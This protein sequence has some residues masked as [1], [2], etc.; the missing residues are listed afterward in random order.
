MVATADIGKTVASAMRDPSAPRVIELAGGNY[1]PRD[2]ATVFSA[3]LGRSVV[4][5]EIPESEC[6]EVL[7]PYGFTRRT[8]EAW[9]ELFR[10]FNSGRVC[11]QTPVS[12]RRGQTT[13]DEVVA[14]IAQ[15]DSL[16]IEGNEH[17]NQNENTLPTADARR[18]SVRGACDG[19]DR[20]WIGH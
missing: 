18:P 3:A 9:R 14:A 8:I 19:L 5:V 2:V 7:S 16:T 4:P 13:L 10:G 1:S 6:S 17:A 20:K 11:F 15:T 12:V